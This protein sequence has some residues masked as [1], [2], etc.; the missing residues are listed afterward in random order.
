MKKF[1]SLLA[2]SL[3]TVGF[4]SAQCTIDP[5]NTDLFNPD[6]NTVP[7]A[8]VGTAYDETLKF[9]IPVSQDISISGF[10]VTV[11]V[12][13]VVLNGVTGLP[14]GL[15]WVAN[16]AG[17]LYLPDTHGCGRTTGTT[18]ATPGNYPISF[19]GLMYLR[20]SISGFAFDTA[21]TI[22]QV[23]EN[24]YG[25]TFSIDV[26]AQ[27]STCGSVGI[28][29]LN[30][31]LNSALSVYPNPSTGVFNLNLNSKNRVNGEV[32]VVDVT[33]KKVFTQNLDVVGLYSTTIDLNGKA[34]GIYTVQL[35]TAEGFASKTISIE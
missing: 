27:G 3:F 31:D 17:P 13:S 35:R 28:N 11:F 10:N 4:V 23:I 29:D 34:K 6:P 19:D 30:T 33:G 1:Y 32:V 26:V 24:E 20:A 7:C 8:I 16:P 5:N 2:F 12:D 14:T 18:T 21:L 22:D 25:K 15:S 9:Y